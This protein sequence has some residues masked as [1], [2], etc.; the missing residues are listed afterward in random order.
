MSENKNKNYRRPFRKGEL[1]VAGRDITYK[2]G[3][4]NENPDKLIALKGMDYIEDIEKDTHV[5]SQLGTRRQKLIKKSY[6]IKPA[7]VNGKSTTKTRETCDFTND[8]IKGMK[9]SFLKDIEAML[10]ATSKGFSVTEINYKYVLSGRWKGKVGLASL[11][12]KPAKHFS[13]KYDDYGNYGLRQIDPDPSGKNLPLDKYIHLVAGNNDENPY[14]DSL[15]AKC[16][17]WSWLKKNE[18]KF[19]AIFSERFGMPQV[20]VELPANVKDGDTTKAEEIIEG[21]Q[22]ASGIVVPKGFAVK[23]LEAVRRGDVNYD[24]FIE[25]C[26]KEMSKV[27]LGATLISEEGKRGQGSYALGHEHAGVMEDYIIFDAAMTAEAINEQLIKRLIDINFNTEDYP[28]FEWIGVNVDSLISF[29]QSIGIFVDRGMKIPISWIRD[30]AGIPEA[31]EGED[32]LS[33][34]QA[35]FGNQKIVGADNRSFYDPL[36]LLK[37]KENIPPD[38]QREIAEINSLNERYVKLHAE[39]HEKLIKKFSADVKKKATDGQ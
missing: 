38:I 10:D 23:F 1:T 34:Q 19:W 7:E 21:L 15:T 16:A 39:K 13:F 25:R 3:L 35:G 37:F 36:D 22:T 12:F 27:L 29:A 9:G 33:G 26:N 11:R 18:A 14:G 32:V 20:E 5:S 2:Y 17:F 8:Q 31:K 6:R 30:Q 4:S 24:N 28:V